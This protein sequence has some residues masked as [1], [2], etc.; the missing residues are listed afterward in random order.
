MLIIRFGAYGMYLVG[1][2][3]TRAKER[4]FPRVI[5]PGL[6]GKMKSSDKFNDFAFIFDKMFPT[7]LLSNNTIEMDLD[8]V[9]NHPSL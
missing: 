6:I 1:V 3:Q 7:K 9:S 2:A 5:K 4:M 8:K